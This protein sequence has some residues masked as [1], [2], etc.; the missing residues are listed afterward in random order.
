[1]ALLETVQ[2]LLLR[3]ERWV[4][5]TCLL[6]LLVLALVQIVARNFFSI[7]LPTADTLTRYLVL[8]V[9]FFGAILAIHGQ[10][11]ISLDVLNVWLGQRWRDRLHR[12]LHFIGALVTALLCQAAW[13]YW[14]DEW[15]HVSEQDRWMTLLALI[16]PVGF[17]LLSLHFLLA[18]LIGKPAAE[19]ERT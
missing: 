3:I 9:T 8:Y 14:Q 4:G 19:P 5:G 1:L 12:P 2:G 11:H 16:L 13:A 17:G 15:T 7:G 18:G 10:R 6:L